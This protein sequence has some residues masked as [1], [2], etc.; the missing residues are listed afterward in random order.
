M[1]TLQDR[2]NVNESNTWKS[3]SSINV[4]SYIH[5]TQAAN[6]NCDIKTFNRF[7]LFAPDIHTINKDDTA[8]CH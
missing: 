8:E 5:R 3:V 2:L 1:K 6:S 4:K 7:T